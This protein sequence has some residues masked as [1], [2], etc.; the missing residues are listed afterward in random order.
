MEGEF[1]DNTNS[2]ASWLNGNGFATSLNG[3]TGFYEASGSHRFNDKFYTG[4][5]PSM[6]EPNSIDVD[7]GRTPTPIRTIRLL[8]PCGVVTSL[9]RVSTTATA[10]T[11][12]PMRTR[13]LVSM[14]C[15]RWTMV[16]A[17]PVLSQDR[18]AWLSSDW[19]LP[20]LV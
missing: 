10:A 15:L 9:S 6:N 1:V 13:R 12:S 11:V 16:E 8:F 4:Y 3:T 14:P 20:V 7:E 2:V 19:A 18:L 17:G 5:G